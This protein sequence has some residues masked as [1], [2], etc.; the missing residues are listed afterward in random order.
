MTLLQPKNEDDSNEENIDND[1]YNHE[2]KD[3]RHDMPFSNF[4]N[5]INVKMLKALYNSISFESD[6]IKSETSDIDG[7]DIQ[8][9]AKAIILDGDRFL[10]L[11]DKYSNFWDLPGGH[12]ENWESAMTGLIRE[13]REETNLNLDNIEELFIKEMKL[14][15]ETKPVSFYIAEGYGQI[16]LSEEHTDCEWVSLSESENFNLGVFHEVLREVLKPITYSGGIVA[17]PVPGFIAEDIY[18]EG[19]EEPQRLHMTL[20]YIN[21][22]GMNRLE[23]LNIVKNNIYKVGKPP[24]EGE[25]FGTRRFEGVKTTLKGNNSDTGKD[26][27]VLTVNIPEIHSWRR[28]FQDGLK[29]DGLTVNVENEFTPHIT[30]AYINNSEKNL[31]EHTENRDIKFERVEIWMDDERH[32]VDLKDDTN[33]E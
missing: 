9:S 13:V 5:R 6:I 32:V 14:G 4:T 16:R 2:N 24:M 29:E 28:A 17:L 7:K 21:Y 20:A 18:I 15:D 1:L 11:K 23:W 26:A 25:I 33:L 31:I 12:V 3:D 22:D 27:L 30:L 10:I 8:F 19:Y